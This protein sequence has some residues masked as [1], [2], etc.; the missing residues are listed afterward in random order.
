MVHY[1]VEE[2]I[3]FVQWYY[4]VNSIR[5]IRELFSGI[6]PNRQIPARSSVHI[7]KR[8]KTADSIFKFYNKFRKGV[9][10]LNFAERGRKTEER[11]EEK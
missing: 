1:S 2:R 7:I 3:S 6:F 10:I 9:N 8:F 11:K 5:Q 4:R